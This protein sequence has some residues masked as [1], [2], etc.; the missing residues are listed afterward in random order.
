M[1]EDMTR[2]IPCLFCNGEPLVAHR[3]PETEEEKAKSSLW[4]ILDCFNDDCPL[5][6]RVDAPTLQEAVDLW[7]HRVSEP[8]MVEV[9]RGKR[10]KQE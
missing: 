5:H 4:V 7:N 9:K 2:P 3:L 1:P 10:R 8:P 6:C